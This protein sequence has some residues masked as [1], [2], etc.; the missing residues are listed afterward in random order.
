MKVKIIEKVASSHDEQFVLDMLRKIEQQTVQAN[1]HV[2]DL[3][4]FYQ[5]MVEEHGVVLQ[6][7]AQ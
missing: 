1:G 4:D 6:R 7:L 5:R 3:D 2:F